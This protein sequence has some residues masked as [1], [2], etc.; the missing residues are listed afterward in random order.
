MVRIAHRSIEFHLS[1]KKGRSPAFGTNSKAL[2]FICERGGRCASSIGFCERVAEEDVDHKKSPSL[3]DSS[4]EDMTIRKHWILVNGETWKS[5]TL[6][7]CNAS[8]TVPPF[9]N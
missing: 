4:E 6:N 8:K 5:L 9:S 7:V 1:M 2:L 3:D